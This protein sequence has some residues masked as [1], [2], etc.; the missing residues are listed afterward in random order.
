MI[1]QALSC[2]LIDLLKKKTYTDEI[3]QDIENRK[4]EAPGPFI[5]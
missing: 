2:I 1:I 3:T 5:T 4:D